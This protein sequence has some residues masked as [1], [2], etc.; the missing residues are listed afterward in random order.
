[1]RISLLL[2]GIV[3][4]VGAVVEHVLIPPIFKDMNLSF[5]KL[6]SSVLPSMTSAQ[7]TGNTLD[8]LNGDYSLGTFTSAMYMIEKMSDL[9]CYGV[10]IVGIGIA[11][12]GVFT[13]TKKYMVLNNTKSE[14]LEIL[15]KRLASGEITKEDFKNL[16]NYVM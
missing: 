3:I 1:M 15:K 7:T 6:E 4:I 8:S 11:T 5:T 14:A 16:K 12:F 13:N 2:I 10:A 9:A